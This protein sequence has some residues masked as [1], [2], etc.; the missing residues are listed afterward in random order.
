MNTVKAIVKAE[1][2]SKTKQQPNAGPC[3]WCCG[4]DE[5][6][7]AEITEY[8]T[9]YLGRELVRNRSA[10]MAKLVQRGYAERVLRTFGKWDWNPC[11]IPLDANIRLSKKDCPQVVDPA[12]PEQV[13]IIPRRS[14]FPSCRAGIVICV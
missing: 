12:L 2:I 5:R 3:C 6:E 13:R 1:M 14:T 11:S 4:T 8:L 7:V 9:E 10:K